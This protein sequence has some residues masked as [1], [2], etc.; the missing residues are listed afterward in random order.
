[1]ATKSQTKVIT[2]KV[3]FSFLHVFEPHSVEDDKEKK[4]SAA[5]LIPKKDSDTIADI[6]AAVEAAIAA[7]KEKFGKAFAVKSKLKLPL[8]DG[9]EE[10]E[11]DP[12]YENHWFLNA[13]S[14]INSKPTV[15][16][17]D[18]KTVLTSPDEFYSGCYGRVS[19]NFY[20]F[21]K[22]G[23]AGVAAGLNNLMKLSDGEKLSGSA[24]AQ[25]DFADFAEGEDEG[26]SEFF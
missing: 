24:S 17:R 6:E 16:A 26:A 5:I 23:N 21:S 10:K 18:A 7:G 12:V 1:M 13:S 4:Y 9:D 20:P 19:L 2:G 25:V 11:G 3:R 14:S 8:R 15:V 22:N